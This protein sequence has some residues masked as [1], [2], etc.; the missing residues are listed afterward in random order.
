MSVT[1]TIYYK[2]LLQ[3]LWN[4]LYDMMMRCNVNLLYGFY[5]IF[6]ILAMK[7]FV[8]CHGTSR[9]KLMLPASVTPP[10]SGDDM[11]P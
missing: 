6:I 5:R 1:C 11:P 8:A 9:P 10:G 3:F 4:L 7:Q 2:V